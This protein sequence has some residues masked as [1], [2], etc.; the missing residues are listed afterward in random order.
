MQQTAHKSIET[1]EKTPNT[2]QWGLHDLTRGLAWWAGL[3]NDAFFKE[4]SVPPPAISYKETHLIT[5]GHHVIGKNDSGVGENFARVQL[6]RPLWQILVILIHEMTHAWQALHAKPSNSWYHNKEFRRMLMEFGVVCD[7]SGC[8]CGVKD[9]F[10][11]LLKKHGI[12]FNHP[13]DSDGFIKIPPAIKPKGKS[14]LKKW[15]CG[16]TNVRVAVKDFQANCLKCGNDF[17]R[18]VP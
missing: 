15:S 18:A 17:E 9:P 2:N 4:Q 1:S 16:C 14:K 6:S 13:M 5:I 10:V 7:K 11:S 8:N 3:F 12:V